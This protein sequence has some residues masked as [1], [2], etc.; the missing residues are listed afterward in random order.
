MKNNLLMVT[1]ISSLMASTASAG[2]NEWTAGWGMGASEHLIDDGNSNSLNVSCPDD[3]EGHV[4][5]YATI[6]GKEYSSED[7]IGFDVIVD[8]VIYRHPFYTDCR[9]CDASFPGFWQA[10]R[11]ANRLELMA[12]GK[13]VRLSTNNIAAVL[14]ALDSPE[15]TCRSAW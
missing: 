5:A 14:P 1:L 15:N 4:S 3:P 12:E 11:K 10:L 9:A 8:G 7:D 6:G 13:V 2:T